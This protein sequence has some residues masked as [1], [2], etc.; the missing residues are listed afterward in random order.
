MF[1][2]A[3]ITNDEGRLAL[4]KHID[5]LRDA[6]ADLLAKEVKAYNFPS[7]CMRYGLDPGEEDEANRSKRLYARKR[8][9]SKQSSF[10][11]SLAKQLVEDFEA[12]DFVKIV[13]QFTSESLF[14]ISSIT[15]RAVIDELIISR[16]RFF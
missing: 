14:K 6:I 7:V 16:G 1:I 12:I 15:R 4:L 8:L 3:E 11:I 9:H 2:L 13:E 5:K 10:V